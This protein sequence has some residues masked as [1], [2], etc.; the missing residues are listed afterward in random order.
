M[1]SKELFKS[2]KRVAIV[3]RGQ[4]IRGGGG[5]ERRFV[6]FFNQLTDTK[7]SNVYLVLNQNLCRSTIDLGYLSKHPNVLIIPD[8]PLLSEVFF[9]LI[10]IKF[11]VGKKF[12]IVHLVLIQKSLIPFYFFAR[13]LKNKNLYIVGSVVSYIFAYKL[14]LG[15]LNRFLYGLYIN[16]C[17][18]IDSLYPEIVLSDKSYTVT[19]CSFIDYNLFLPGL[20]ENI[21][22]F[23]G[24]LIKQKNPLMF[25]AAINYLIRNSHDFSIRDW[26]FFLCGGGPLHRDLNRYIKDNGLEDFVKIGKFSM[27]ELLSRSR[28]FVS[29]QE[30]ENYPSQALLE[31]IATENSII[32]TDVGS[33]R[34]VCDDNTSL[35]IPVDQ[36]ALQDA[37]AQLIFT[38]GFSHTVLHEAAERIKLNH[39][40]EKFEEYLFRIWS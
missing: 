2:S 16:A 12:D 29:L 20:K 27:P 14:N 32:V 5:A 8:V 25:L 6:R 30:H 19:P 34:L 39:S 38:G 15:F 3:I 10:L 1:E 17:D 21:V 7:K 35:L 24:R 28:I 9:N 36:K 18:H 37:M 23:S 22:V 33:T 40:V 13:F 26:T 31:A 11:L 4:S